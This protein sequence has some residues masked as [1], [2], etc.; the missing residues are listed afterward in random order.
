[1]T[2]HMIADWMRRSALKTI[3]QSAAMKALHLRAQLRGDPAVAA[4]RNP[5]SGNTVHEAEEKIDDV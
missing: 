5:A 1:M 4:F 2:E 3:L